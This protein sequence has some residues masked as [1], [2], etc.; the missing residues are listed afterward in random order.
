MTP[1]ITETSESHKTKEDNFKHENI[2]ISY[3]F[4]S[5]TDIESNFLTYLFRFFRSVSISL[6]EESIS[7]GSI[8]TAY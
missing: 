3:E 8:P 4:V 2:G 1:K 6:R 5:H 7:I